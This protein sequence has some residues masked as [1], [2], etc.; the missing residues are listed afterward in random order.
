M[1]AVHGNDRSGEHYAKLSRGVS[2]LFLSG[3]FISFFFLLD[4]RG[5]IKV[6]LFLLESIF[7][8][9]FSSFYEAGSS[10]VIIFNKRGRA[11]DEP[12]TIRQQF[13]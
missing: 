2:S 5:A 7:R 4:K 11:R 8:I 9:H 6:H 1:L 10:F 3:V 12:P 13:F